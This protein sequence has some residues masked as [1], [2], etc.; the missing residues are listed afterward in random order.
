[1]TNMVAARISLWQSVGSNGRARVDKA[2]R[3][4]RAAEYDAL[5][6]MS[7]LLRSQFND[8]APAAVGLPQ[9]LDSEKRPIF[10]K[11]NACLAS[12]QRIEVNHELRRNSSA[13][14]S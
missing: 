6:C 2:Q 7:P 3:Q 11:T 5:W 13:A 1:M 10:I 9:R 4:Q 14:H 12:S 8:R